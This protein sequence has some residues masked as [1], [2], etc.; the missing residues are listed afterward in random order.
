MR[1]FKLRKLLMKKY[2]IVIIIIFIYSYERDSNSQSSGE[3]EDL[4][5]W[6]VSTAKGL[7]ID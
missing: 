6:M 3:P 1:L 7:Y 5:D 2:L 4:D